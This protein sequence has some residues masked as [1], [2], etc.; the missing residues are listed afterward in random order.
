MLMCPLASFLHV[1]GDWYTEICNFLRFSLFYRMVAQQAGLYMGILLY[2]QRS[3]V[4]LCLGVW[5]TEINIKA[6]IIDR[7]MF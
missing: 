1:R 3:R 2:I 6:A 4:M 7:L 5:Q